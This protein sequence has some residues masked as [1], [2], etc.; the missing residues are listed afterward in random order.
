[1]KTLKLLFVA[2]MFLIVNVYI[3]AQDNEPQQEPVFEIVISGD[4]QVLA[5][6]YSTKQIDLFDANDGSLITVIELPEFVQRITLSPT[7]DRFVWTDGTGSV[8]LYDVVTMTDSILIQG[9]AILTGPI[10]W[11]PVNDLLAIAWGQ[12]VEI[13]DISSGIREWPNDQPTF[14]AS[15]IS[16]RVVRLAW[17][18]NGEQLATSHYAT[19]TID[20]TLIRRA[21]QV[22]DNFLGTTGSIPIM[23]DETYGGGSIA[24]SPD[25][26]RIAMLPSDEIAVYDLVLD[27]IIAE[28]VFEE[29]YSAT[30]AWSPNGDYVATGGRTVRIWDANVLEVIATIPA[31]NNVRTIHW[32]P[33]SQ[34]IFSNIGNDGLSISPNPAL[35]DEE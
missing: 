30:I 28:A 27:E 20:P 6:D 17:S 13:Y 34:Y 1:M 32:S 29:Q 23:M 8:H 35:N 33:D 15:D 12:D 3:Q 25:G 31:N 19:S 10:A 14:L 9:G 22:W 7:G 4:G 26:T 2:L 18:P 11:N 16:S 21:I 5:V 24:W